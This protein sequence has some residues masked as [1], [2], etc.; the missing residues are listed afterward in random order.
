MVAGSFFRKPRVQRRVFGAS[1]PDASFNRNDSPERSRHPISVTGGSLGT[2]AVP[3]TAVTADAVYAANVVRGAWR[4]PT[5]IPPAI[6]QT[7]TATT[8]FLC[9]AGLCARAQFFAA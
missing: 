3:W 1:A 4:A 8:A 7:A 2:A 5:M 9:R 6:T